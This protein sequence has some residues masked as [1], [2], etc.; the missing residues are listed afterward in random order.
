MV[1]VVQLTRVNKLLACPT[2]AR[3]YQPR[4]DVCSIL[5]HQLTLQSLLHSTPVISLQAI[6]VYLAIVI[7]DIERFEF[8]AHFFK[9]SES[10]TFMVVCKSL[11]IFQI[12]E[13]LVARS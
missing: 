11:A 10:T 5:N 4:I 7:F 2:K 12:T 6:V 8:C 13:N 1:D 9:L 3:A